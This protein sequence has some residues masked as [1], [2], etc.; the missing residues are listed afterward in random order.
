MPKPSASPLPACWYEGRL[1]ESVHGVIGESFA[2][3]R[4][5][6]PWTVDVDA[7]PRAGRGGVETEAV[8]EACASR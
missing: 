5:A 8:G 3:T 6:D 2:P 4:V 7:P 1:S